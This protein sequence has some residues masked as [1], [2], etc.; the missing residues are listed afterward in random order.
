MKNFILNALTIIVFI[1]PVAASALA[2][3]ESIVLDKKTGDYIINYA[4]ATGKIMQSRFV[5]STKIDPTLRSRFEYQR[6]TFRY[7]YKIRNGADSKQPLIRLILVPVWNVWSKTPLPRTGDE[8]YQMLM[9]NVTNPLR[10][11]QTVNENIRLVDAPHGWSCMVMPVGGEEWAGYRVG[12]SFED[13]D[14]G[15]RNGLQPGN[16]VSGFGFTSMY[17]P[18][19]GSAQLAGSGDGGPGFTDEGPDG[20]IS[21]QLEMIMKNDHVPRNAAI[22]TIAIPSPYDAAV[23]ME[24]IRT[25]MLTWSNKQILEPVFASQLDRY[26]V[27]ATE[28]FRLNQNKAAIEHLHTLRKMLD[29]EHKI[30]DHDNEDEEDSPEHKAKT[31][32]SIDRLAARVLDFNLRYVLKWADKDDEQHK[33]KKKDRH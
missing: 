16:S 14:E 10:L 2:P 6:G 1:V 20:E 26:I 24:R 15:G 19:I 7:S 27:A 12:C 3:G 33:E 22:P 28:A 23:L 32:N 4:N 25:E 8:E 13:V 11:S 31:R 30:L 17:L 29:R 9:K 21:D 18:G 5:P